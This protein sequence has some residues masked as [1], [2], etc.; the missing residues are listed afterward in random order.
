MSSANIQVLLIEDD[1]DDADLLR[2]FL[3]QI[4]QP[5]FKLVHAQLLSEGLACLQKQHF[6]IVLLD[7]GLPD[8]SGI[9]GA[10]TLRKQSG[11]IPIIV[12]TGLDDEELALKSLQMDIQ[13][14]L[15]KGQIDKSLLKRAIR[16]AIERKHAMEDLQ[17]SEARFRAFFEMANVGA[18]Q[19]DPATYGF[20]QV[21]DR[22]CRITGYS[23]EELL[24][25]TV[26]DITHPDDQE[27]D[28]DHFRQLTSGETSPYTEEKRYIR[29]DGQVVWVSVSGTIIRDTHGKA[30][31]G[32]GVIQDITEHKNAEQ[33]LRFS[34]RRFKFTMEAAELG[35]WDLNLSDRSMWRSQRY[36]QI[37]GHAEPL[38]TW[39]YETFLEHVLP[40]DRE[41]VDQ[42]F[43]KALTES[44]EW[45]IECRIR[46]ADGAIRWIWARGHSLVD[47]QGGPK[48]MLGIVRDITKQKQLEDEIKHM[49][50]HDVLT[51]LPNRRLFQEIIAVEAAQAKRYG[52]KLAILFLDLD[53]FKDVN[54]TLGHAAGDELLKEAAAKLRSTIRQRDTLARIGG[55]EFNVL[56]A[57][58]SKVKDISDVVVKIADCFKTSFLIAG[59]EVT[60]TASIGI[61][62]YPDDSEEIESLLR[63]ADRAMYQ[64]KASGRN[65]Y[66]FYA[67]LNNIRS[68]E[69]MKL[70]NMLRQALTRKELVVYYQPQVS[71]D[72]RR[73]ASA[74]ALVRWRHPERGVLEPKDFIQAARDT[75]FISEIDAWVLKSVCEQLR[76]WHD[77]GLPPIRIT[78]NLSAKGFHS[79]GF[80]GI[81]RDILAATGVSPASLSFEITESMAM[82]NMDRS[83]ARAH[84][85]MELGVHLSIDDFGTGHS[86]LMNLK[87]LFVDKLQ[88]D[89]SFVQN[90]ATD[91]DDRA[92]I[93]AVTSMARS[94]S[95][96][97][98]A[99]GVETKD[100]LGFLRE[101]G[102]EE[103]QGYLF[104]KPLPIDAFEK[105]MAAS[106]PFKS[107][108]V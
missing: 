99:E 61:S 22:F 64:A 56:L 25:M 29:K 92:L 2:R 102:C 76:I 58:F 38:P 40:E 97:T 74:E 45:N 67:A 44:Q 96:R 12:L 43:Q 85:L 46:C 66:Q 80:V 39:N 71:L 65:T 93:S 6:D 51:G 108:A 90:I 8:S 87:K 1:L 35:V 42:N 14:Y 95:I 86:L 72:T 48:R 77:A 5:V 57:D 100:Q 3:S 62:I 81:V 34:E 33:A 19:V 50:Q 59:N 24:T 15:V 47:E 9:E 23:R 79:P 101:A 60:V 21:N 107:V 10:L 36:D 52:R 17:N 103:I 104:S 55:D 27:A 37:F 73:M 32:V 7:L 26:Q 78:V 54:D 28:Q 49:A 53:H 83:I 84:E 41:A 30:V 106:M 88:I 98:V 68:S 11:R 69:R 91:A 4:H 70:E 20:L 16:Y 13:D 31:L 63:Y 75:G 18:A 94:M 82:S 105:L 89:K